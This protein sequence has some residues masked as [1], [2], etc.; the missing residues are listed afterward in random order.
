MNRWTWFFP[1]IFSPTFLISAL[2]DAFDLLFE[3][4]SIDIFLSAMMFYTANNLPHCLV[5]SQHI[6]L[7]CWVLSFFISDYFSQS[8]SVLRKGLHLSSCSKSDHG[9]FLPTEKYIDAWKFGMANFDKC[10]I[11]LTAFDLGEIRTQAWTNS[12]HLCRVCPYQLSYEVKPNGVWMF[13]LRINGCSSRLHERMSST[14]VNLV[15]WLGERIS[16][17]TN[18]HWSEFTRMIG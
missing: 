13:H 5:Q 16:Q 15:I 11:K 6:P 7:T 12:T 3:Y 17:S 10:R 8:F 18:N 14:T 1:N 9:H 4:L 2:Q